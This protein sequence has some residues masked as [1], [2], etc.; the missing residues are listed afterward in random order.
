MQASCI[1]YIMS[2]DDKNFDLK[3]EELVSLMGAV[4]GK[5]KTSGTRY[6]FT[7]YIYKD[8]VYEVG[9]SDIKTW[10]KTPLSLGLEKRQAQA[11]SQRTIIRAEYNQDKI[12]CYLFPSTRR[13]YDHSDVLKTTVRIHTNVF[14]NFETQVYDKGQTQTTVHK[15]YI[16]YNMSTHNKD[17][18]DTIKAI[19][20][21]ALEVLQWA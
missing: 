11:Q 6:E 17:D 10:R 9:Q 4:C 18:P 13:I 14:I 5:Y 16:N 20:D 15:V 3:K 7:R 1:E 8:L 21:Q 2:Y 19:I 12:P